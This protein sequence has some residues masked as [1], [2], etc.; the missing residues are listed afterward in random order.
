MDRLEHVARR[1]IDQLGVL[2]HE[3]DD[4]GVVAELHR[5][6]R[7]LGKRADGVACH[8]IGVGIDVR[9][10]AAGMLAQQV[11]QALALLP[12][13]RTVAVDPL[14]R[15]RRIEQ[16]EARRP[17]V[18]QRQAVE[19]VEDAGIALGRK[20]GDRDRAN[21]AA[22]DA[23]TQPAEEILRAEHRVEVHRD[24]RQVNRMIFAGETGHQVAEQ[25]VL[26]VPAAKRILDAAAA[27]AHQPQRRGQVILDIHKRA[28]K[29]LQRP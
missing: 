29:G 8:R 12:P 18:A 15:R 3:Y 13:A 22:A 25:L 19:K 5:A 20:A 23:R 26:D 1:G 16:N 24:R 6:A 4:A 7:R 2:V 27:Q 10:G 28:G 17:P 9:R 21:V 14:L 11:A